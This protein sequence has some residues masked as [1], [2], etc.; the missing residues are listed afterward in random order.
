MSLSFVLTIRLLC[1]S[2]V[3]T[4][5][6]LCL[7]FV[8]TNRLLCLKYV[9]SF[10]FDYTSGYYLPKMSLCLI[11][12]YFIIDIICCQQLFSFIFTLTKALILLRFKAGRSNHAL[13]PMPTAFTVWAKSAAIGAVVMA[14]LIVGRHS[15]APSSS[16]A[17]R[18]H[19]VL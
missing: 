2:F 9:P 8:L 19:A 14:E 13:L 1:L 15:N 3:L 7:N 4:I 10:C 5:R 11:F 17:I 18:S 6:L 16:C 12:K